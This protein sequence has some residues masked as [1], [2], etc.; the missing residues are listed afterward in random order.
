MASAQVQESSNYLSDFQSYMNSVSATSS[1]NAVCTTSSGNT[2][3]LQTGRN[4]E[5]VLSGG[6]LDVTQVSNASCQQIVNT[7]LDVEG[8]VKTNINNNIEQYLAQQQSSEQGWLTLALNAQV[9]GATNQTELVT[10]IK[11]AVTSTS[12]Q[13]C[14]NTVTSYNAAVL[15]LCGV[16]D[17]GAVVNISQNSV[18]GAYQSC[19]MD[20]L[21]KAFQNDT[22]L[23]T[24]AQAVNQQ[25]TSQQ[26]GIDSLFRW[27][28]IIAAI[29]AVVVIIGIIIYAVVGGFG[30]GKK[31]EEGAGGLNEQEL[32]LL[33]ESRKGGEGGGSSSIL[34]LLLAEE[35][36]K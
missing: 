3:N 33:A 12:S 34:P 29:V 8:Q 31:P 22:V 13:V 6:S 9:Q 17:N 14:Q 15:D 10:R 20:V 16:Y 35:S 21:V 26:S 18:A 2:L 24:V 32:L 7:N 1:N 23:T 36:K 5:F 28:V 4:C 19:T 27:L 30:G 11:N 25:Q